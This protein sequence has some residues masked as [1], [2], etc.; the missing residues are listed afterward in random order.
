MVV[1]VSGDFD[2]F[3]KEEQSYS[4]TYTFNY[5]AVTIDIHTEYIVHHLLEKLNDKHAAFAYSQTGLTET[6]CILY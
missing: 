2:A 6:T 5:I 1:W 3:D 4:Q